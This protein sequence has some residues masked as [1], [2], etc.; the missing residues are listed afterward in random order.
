MQI[1]ICIYSH[2][3]YSQTYIDICIELNTIKGI[4]IQISFSF[5][6]KFREISNLL[7]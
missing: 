2:I 5:N 3:T 6:E 1:H 7:L 4:K